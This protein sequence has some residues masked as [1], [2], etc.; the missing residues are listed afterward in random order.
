MIEEYDFKFIY[1]NH[2][3]GVYITNEINKDYSEKTAHLLQYNDDYS[4]YRPISKL[5]SK[6]NYK[7]NKNL[8][9]I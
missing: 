9:I 8:F 1:K 5:I 2:A 6:T 3:Y 7:E 4:K